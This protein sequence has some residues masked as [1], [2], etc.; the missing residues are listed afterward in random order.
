MTENLS[1][2]H[3]ANTVIDKNASGGGTPKSQRRKKGW[4]S[5]WVLLTPAGIFLVILIAAT[6]MLFRLSLGIKGAEWSVWTFQNYLSMGES[7]YIRSIILTLK[8]ALL[9]AVLVVVLGYPVAMFLAR[10]QSETIRLLVTFVL[11]LPLFVNLLFQTYGW[12]IILTPAGVLNR[13]LQG[14]GLT[15]RPLILLFNQTGVL[16]GLVQTSF[17]LA[18]LPM[19]SSLRTIPKSLE[20]AGATLGASRLRVLWHVVFPLSLPGVIAGSLLVFAF[21]ASAFVIPFLLGGRRVSMLG[22]L[23]RDQMGPI[24]NWPFGAANGVVLVLIVL[25]LLT[26]YQL[27]TAKFLRTWRQ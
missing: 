12:M 5:P 18:V 26:L 10:A 23:I 27:S 6:L 17:P 19:A 9:S 16:L 24:L 2:E 22:V 21:N 20:E 4:R 11:L 25:V 1:S 13:V 15:D 14:L 3:S 7:L 8:L